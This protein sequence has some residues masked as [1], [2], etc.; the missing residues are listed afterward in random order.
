[1]AMHGDMLHRLADEVGHPRPI[2]P[3]Q[4]LHRVLMDAGFKAIIGPAASCSS[5]AEA[6]LGGESR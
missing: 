3:P 5:E 6:A 4:L 1:M 2:W